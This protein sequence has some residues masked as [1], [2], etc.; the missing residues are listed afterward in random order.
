VYELTIELT[1]K[2][3]ELLEEFKKGTGFDDDSHVVIE[4]FY[5]MQEAIDAY[6]QGN[7]KKVEGIIS[8]FTRFNS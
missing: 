2:A 5:S 1:D 4:L 3:H 7:P 6:A 8:T